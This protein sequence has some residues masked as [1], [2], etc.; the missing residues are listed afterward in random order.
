MSNKRAKT[1]KRANQSGAL[2]IPRHLGSVTPISWSPPTTPPGKAI[3]PMQWQAAG[4]AIFKVGGAA[5]WWIADWLAYGES[6][7]GDRIK[8]LAESGVGLSYK[9]LANA[10]WVAGKVEFS[11]RRENLSF[12]H[13]E[14]IAALVGSEQSTWLDR[15]EREGWTATELRDRVKQHERSIGT[16]PLSRIAERLADRQADADWRDADGDTD[17]DAAA[18]GEPME[19]GEATSV[20]PSDQPEDGTE[21]ALAMFRSGSDKLAKVAKLDLLGRLVAEGS[22]TSLQLADVCKL[23]DDV[24]RARGG[25][26]IKHNAVTDFL[27][28]LGPDALLAAMPVAMRSRLRALFEIQIE[29]EREANRPATMIHGPAAF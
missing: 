14:E 16:F 4:K 20:Q 12:K 18:A 22:V 13:H 10:A 24:I 7:F 5:K 19:E 2:M 11:R 27:E 29:T 3:P 26:A 6:K 15:A 25:Q 21:Q 23:A 8:E 17:A 1:P 9:S 28:S